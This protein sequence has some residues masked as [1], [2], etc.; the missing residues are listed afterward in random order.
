MPIEWGLLTQGLSGPTQYEQ[1]QARDMQEKLAQ[2]SLAQAQ[3]AT[4][5][6][7]AKLRE[8]VAASNRT[9]KFAET[10]AAKGSDPGNW[11]SVADAL[12]STGDAEN[13][14]HAQ[15]MYQDHYESDKLNA[16]ISGK[17]APNYNEWLAQSS[18]P[19]QAPAQAP[20][21]APM[22]TAAPAGPTADQYKN[23]AQRLASEVNQVENPT[24]F[25]MQGVVNAYA[26]AD[27]AANRTN[28]LAPVAPVAAP[29]NA[30]QAQIAP[31]SNQQKI[32]A[33]GSS[34]YKPAQKVADLMAKMHAPSDLQRLEDEI[35]QYKQQGVPDTDPAIATRRQ[36]IA[37]LGYGKDPDF[38]GYAIAQGQGFKGTLLD[39]KKAQANAE[40]A[41][42]QP[43]APQA[44]VA[45]VDANGNTRYVRPETA[46]QEGLAPASTATKPLTQ[47]QQLK[48][49]K[50]RAADEGRIRSAGS[51]ANELERIA[52]SLLGNPEKKIPPDKGLRGITGVNAMLPSMP[53]SPAR[54]A[55]QK[56]DTFKGKIMAL[57]RQIQSSEGKLGNMAVQ[58][59][60]F[61]S[62]AVEKLDPAAPN[63]AEQLRDAVRQARSL[64]TSM[65]STFADSYEA[66]PPA[67]TNTQKA[68]KQGNAPRKSLGDIFK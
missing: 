33:L 8:M 62:D 57:G 16:I 21:A 27:E 67:N 11:R 65:K 61:V 35:A 43:P 22:Q 12:H 42:V 15:Q 68:S 51:T 13:V 26:R 55:Q 31:Q 60:K 3:Q 50:D 52:D 9:K 38:P 2:Q 47:Q 20:V 59:W 58:E 29:A 37:S 7:E 36:L 63:F 24:S 14:M 4:H 25:D 49:N 39:Y 40:R 54:A 17:Q 19:A 10:M 5:L 32:L 46:I 30:L 44:P 56:L 41:P 45:V 1:S 34:N 48:L 6:N 64:E 53:G 28:N 23:V 66:A 18:G